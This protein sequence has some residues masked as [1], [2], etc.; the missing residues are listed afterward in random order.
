MVSMISMTRSAFLLLCLV[1]AGVAPAAVAQVADFAP[2]T[3]ETLLNP[4]P[5]DWLMY[6]R[7][8][9]NHR[10]SPLDQI[11][12][13]NVGQLNLA[14][15]RGM[16]PGI[17]EH[18]PLVYR[19]VMY[20]ANPG[21]LQALDAA[22]G[23]LIWD[24][25]R[26]LPQGSGPRA[27]RTITIFEDL[28]I[29][30][31]PDRAVVAVDARTGELRWETRLAFASSGPKVFDGK[32]ISGMT[33]NAEVR[34]S[35]LALDARTGR[36][37]WRFDTAAAPDDPG[38]DTWGDLPVEQRSTTPWGLPGAYDPI[39]NLLYWGTAN[40]SP[41][42]RL[43]RHGDADA[44]P[45]SAPSELYSNSTLALDPDTGELDWYYQHLPGD[46]WDADHT[47]ERILL[48]TRLDPNPNSVKWINPGIPRGQERDVV[49]SLG[50]PGGIWV[51]DR[52]DGRFLWATPFPY[53]VPEFNISRIDVETGKTYLNWDLAIES[54]DQPRQVMC[55]HNT[56][57][58]WPMAYH[59]GNNS[60]YIPF[61]DQCLDRTANPDDPR[62]HGPRFG[63]LRPGADPDEY[64]G[65][66]R[67]DMETGEMER[68]Y[69][70][71]APGN[72]AALLTA[73]DLLFW[74]DMNR[75]FRAFD[76]DTG[77]VLWENILGG[78]IQM[79]TITYAVDGK[80]YV[81]V[82]TGDGAS[83]TAGPLTVVP[84]INPPRGHNSIYVFALP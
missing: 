42:V 58:Y 68:I 52:D 59:P 76:A 64:A 6:S 29:Y 9:D 73:G 25:Q 45:R 14:W 61:H 17:H 49:V 38:G 51:N 24:Y 63:I 53:D 15:V 84:E 55:F 39:R 48:R 16:A 3:N 31:A 65:I 7:T 69:S 23:D 26:S 71:R 4:S 83:G 28:I 44:V 43:K 27:G 62:G 56:K 79:S 80:Q 12:R 54:Y 22:T 72:G 36:E 30:A 78:I 50:E 60:L 10:Y 46:D 40:P 8:Y 20:V 19:G 77:E 33:E 2:V 57:S 35:I 70:Q 13:Q 11:N 67:F 66:A 74:G 37:L 41:H 81:A 34:D 47:Q 1:L 18:I 32:V 75:R 82:L 21:G 5:D